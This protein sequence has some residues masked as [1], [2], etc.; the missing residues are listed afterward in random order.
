MLETEKIQSPERS[1]EIVSMM[2]ADI[3]RH[4]GTIAN[5]SG[6]DAEELV[7]NIDSSAAKKTLEGLSDDD[8]KPETVYLNYVSGDIIQKHANRSMPAREAR[9]IAGQTLREEDNKLIVA[10]GSHTI[11]ADGCC[12]IYSDESRLRLCLVHEL[13]H[14][15]DYANPRIVS[16]EKTYLKFKKASN[17]LKKI[18]P[19]PRVQSHIDKKSPMEVRAYTIQERAPSFPPII[20]FDKLENG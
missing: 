16:N 1:G 18:L 14:A 4:V 3:G 19:F 6:I 15:A 13:Q 10:V 7:I 5:L 20:T 11:C 12:T 17:F 9:A 8:T 2:S